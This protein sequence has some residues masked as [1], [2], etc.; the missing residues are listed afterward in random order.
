[1]VEVNFYL[2][3]FSG[4]A[5]GITPC[6]L[7]MLS[8]FG[9]SLILTEE[10]KKFL[11][12]STGL[13][14]G[15]VMAYIM[16]SIILLYLFH[17]IRRT[18]LIFNFVF[19]GILIFIGIWEILDSKK[20]ESYIFKTPKKV[21]TLLNNFIQ[22]NSGFYAFLVGI[23]FVLI[24]IP[25]FG[26]VYLS[27]LANLHSNPLLFAFIV[28]YIIGMLTPIIFVLILMRLG[29]ESAKI[30]DFRLNN[31]T[32]LRILSGIILIFL[33]VYLLMNQIILVI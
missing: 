26:N 32:K 21:K 22:R 2:A 30:N 12:I 7:L 9:T 31:R 13:I 6:I 28:I 23:I 11:S 19:A 3:F 27:L 10:K 17:L 29:L 8:V 24:K 33:A 16:M 25:C 14:S 5:I 15:M 4:L 20:E 1:M 18:V